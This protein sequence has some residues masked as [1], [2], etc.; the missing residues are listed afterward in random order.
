MKCMA[1]QTP[2]RLGQVTKGSSSKGK[3]GLL[4]KD[5]AKQWVTGIF[6]FLV[7]C[8]FPLVYHDYY[9]DMIE[10][11]Y[12]TF[13]VCVGILAVGVFLVIPVLWYQWYSKLTNERKAEEKKRFTPAAIW[14]SLSIPD[15]A[16]LAFWLVELISTLTSAYP[17]ESFWGNE[18]RFSGL[19][20]NTLYVF[21]Y[22]AISRLMTF[23]HWYLDAFLGFSMLVCLL[24]I[25]DY[26]KMDMLHFRD[27]MSEEQL[28]M[29]VSTLGNIN[30]YTAFV[31]MVS[32]VASVLFADAREMGR[33][34]FYFVCMII[35]FFA[36]IM[37][38]SDN[39]YL[40]LAALFGFLPL[41][42]FKKRS[43][44][45]SYLMIVFSFL[46][47]VQCIGWINAAFGDRVFGMDS[48]F[49]VL[50]HFKGL[51]PLLLLGWAGI[52]VWYYLDKKGKI[53]KEDTV[54]MLPRYLWIGVLVLAAAVVFVVLY[55]CNVA[56]NQEKYGQFANYL[57]FND[58]WG[59]HRGYIWRIAL[60]NF[61]EFS[62]WHKIVGHGPDTFGIV[63]YMNNYEDMLMRYGEIFDNAHNEYL[64]FLITTGV[65]GL[66]SYVTFLV[67]LI[68]RGFKRISKNPAVAA[69]LFA[70][71]CYSAQAFVNLNLP[72]ATPIMWMFLMMTMAAVRPQEQGE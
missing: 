46:S 32:A 38:L 56:G 60:E 67:S 63:T 15:K 44:I 36:L 28:Q 39:A 48:V 24:G 11:K 61:N 68:I 69:M 51:L 6:A 40:A 45:R 20:L 49:N 55:D 7:L 72:I 71:I 22:F 9:F 12:K 66:V 50:I 42:L 31:A 35:S 2:R 41:Y 53:G 17:F 25:T 43:G 64:N 52:A 70:V 27:R 18:G 3:D 59:T 65:A 29:F 47:V 13:C 8:I 4:A 16:I 54:G 34:I 5:T 1:D 62:I 37:G 57:I 58:D 30:T 10:T 23:K 21:A 19:F 26:F 33:K 14:K